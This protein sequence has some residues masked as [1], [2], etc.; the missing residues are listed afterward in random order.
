MLINTGIK[1]LGRALWIEVDDAEPFP[2]EAAKRT[3][4]TLDAM[5]RKFSEAMAQQVL[6]ISLKDHKPTVEQT[7]AQ[8]KKIVDGLNQPLDV[9]SSGKCAK[10][11]DSFHD[12]DVA[13][14]CKF[15]GSAEQRRGGSIPIIPIQ[16]PETPDLP[17]STADGVKCEHSF[18]PKRFGYLGGKMICTRCGIEEPQPISVDMNMAFPVTK[19]P[20]IPPMQLPESPAG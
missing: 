19:A 5:A 1:L 15:C 9:Q 14:F 12:F 3:Q 13:G 10:S 17:C 16:S 8:I 6:E 7:R 4:I 2:M 18:I 11:G 20:A